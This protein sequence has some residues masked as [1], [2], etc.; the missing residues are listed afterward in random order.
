MSKEFLP[1]CVENIPAELKALNQW[2]L[3]RGEQRGDR[4][5]K[6]PYS[7][8]G[9]RASSSDSDTWTDF[10]SAVEA[11]K[12][13][14]WDG[15]G[16][17]FTQGG[18]LTGIDLDHCLDSEGK[19][20]LKTEALVNALCSYTE[21]SV[22]GKG[23]HVIVRGNLEK[24]VRTSSRSRIDI[25]VEIYSHGRY[26]TVTG[27]VFGGMAEIRDGQGVIDYLSGIISPGDNGKRG[28]P[29][30]AKR[31]YLGNGELIRVC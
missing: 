7:A 28:Q 3:W 11:Y 17:V 8:S 26:F 14:A 1:V 9:N 20:E 15:I 25:P 4:I 30:G 24:G 5:T 27:R 10:G 19:L 13:G 12:S 23:L 16:F 31:P 2:V 6:V 29:S 22:S 18:G 21:Y